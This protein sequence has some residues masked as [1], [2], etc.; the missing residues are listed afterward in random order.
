MFFFIIKNIFFATLMSVL[1]TGC[2]R[3]FGKVLRGSPFFAPKPI[4][5]HS[6]MSD[7]REKIKTTGSIHTFYRSSFV[8]QVAWLANTIYSPYIHDCCS[9]AKRLLFMHACV[10][11]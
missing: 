5:Q 1:S 11:A 9:F 4:N 7:G 2:F 10:H 6:G 8:P 3:M